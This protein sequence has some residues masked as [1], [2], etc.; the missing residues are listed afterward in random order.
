MVG[1]RLHG[2]NSTVS[3][4]HADFMIKFEDYV[5]LRYL[6][7]KFSI[8]QDFIWNTYYYFSPHLR[9]AYKESTR[10]PGKEDSNTTHCSHIRQANASKR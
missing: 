1:P 9:L 6:I 4:L 10:I 7:N 3:Q 2:S 8:E 5:K